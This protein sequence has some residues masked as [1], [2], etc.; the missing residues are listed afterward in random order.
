MKKGVCLTSAFSP[1]VGEILRPSVI[2]HILV[3]ALERGRAT[4]GIVGSLGSARAP[5]IQR[6]LVAAVR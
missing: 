5:S 4:Q 2:A 3:T 1:A 6:G